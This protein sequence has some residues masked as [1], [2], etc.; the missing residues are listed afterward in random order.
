M[1]H[2][3]VV[4]GAGYAG[5][6]AAGRAARRLASSDVR[7]TLIN[8]GD[9][10][11]ERIRL[12]QLAAGQAL[13]DY[14]IRSLLAGTGVDL[15]VGSV[16][17]IDT[18]AQRVEVQTGPAMSPA[19]VEYDTLVYA[20]GSRA[21]IAAIPGVAHSAHS[22]ADAGSA[23]RLRSRLPALAADGGTLAV[24]GG[25]L[26]GI[27]VATELAES[28]PALRV[29]LVSAVA[30]GDWLSQRAQRH[31]Q[32]AFE[33][34]GIETRT[35]V[36]VREVKPGRLLLGGGDQLAADEIV[37]AAGFRVNELAAAA[38]FAVDERGRMAVDETLRSRSD[39]NVYGIGDAAAAHVGDAL[40]RMSCQTS[41]PMGQHVA[42]V[43]A[44]RLTGRT[45][46]AFRL[47][48]VWQN[49]SLGRRDAVTQFTHADDSP[50][51]SILHGRPAARFKEGIGRSVMV[52]LRH[53]GPY[54]PSGPR[55]ATG[56]QPARVSDSLG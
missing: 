38:G 46:T 17:S 47:R 8:D 26:T 15:L 7:I 22:V 23:L 52:S 49:I 14:P 27:E 21:D 2:H 32:L 37:W 35:G 40:T 43:I 10:F 34:L 9:R 3:L 29:Q 16:L 20:L 50:R 24:V 51:W 5:L 11:V 41:L 54:R 1:T 6:A 53:P 48:Y 39:P 31:V 28:H 33:R 25:G 4:L 44:D 12:H 55:S 13:R 42:D 36:L 56:R 30:P 18:A 45:P 19:M